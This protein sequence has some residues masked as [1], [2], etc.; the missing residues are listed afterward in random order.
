MVQLINVN[1][2]A[3]L[4]CV[5]ARYRDIRNL[6]EDFPDEAA[7][8]KER[9]TRIAILETGGRSS[10]DI[11]AVL[12]EAQPFAPAP[13]GCCPLLG[14]QF[15]IWFVDVALH[16]DHR[17]NRPGHPFTLLDLSEAVDEGQLH[18]L[19]W[20]R[21]YASLRK[22]IERILGEQVVVIGMG[23]VEYDAQRRKWQPHWH[24]MIYNVSWARLKAFRKKHYRAQRTGPRPMVRSKRGEPATWFSYMSKLIAFGKVADAYGRTQRVRLSNRLSRE[25]FRYLAERSPTSFIFCINCSLVNRTLGDPLECDELTASTQRKGARR[26][27]W[28][29]ST[30][31]WRDR[32][33]QP[34]RSNEQ[35]GR[36]R[37]LIAA[38]ATTAARANETMCVL[39]DGYDRG[40][41]SRE[42]RAG[43]AI[44]VSTSSRDGVGPPHG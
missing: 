22:R 42:D 35:S 21:L 10:C 34:S 11:A 32:H 3:W 26:Q 37:R 29:R 30:L 20:R 12:R 33:E 27:G 2:A 9:D 41:R 25:Y 44:Y 31:Y 1:R 15:Q 28:P 6:Y 4:N 43:R 18:T 17:L 7:S 39:R 36:S 19:D 14:R 13:V 38:A 8:E 16:L 23:E 40:E 24:L 5:P